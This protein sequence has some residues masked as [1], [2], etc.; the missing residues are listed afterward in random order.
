MVAVYPHIGEEKDRQRVWSAAEKL[1][2]YSFDLRPSPYDQMPD[3]ERI[4]MIGSALEVAGD[5]WLDNHPRQ[6]SWLKMRGVTPDVC[7]KRYREWIAEQM[8]H[9]EWTPCH[10]AQ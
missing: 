8:Q 6:A 7:R 4:L 10:P 2:E 3:N 5:E 9:S 1:A